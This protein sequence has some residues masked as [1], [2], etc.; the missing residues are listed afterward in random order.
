MAILAE[1]V[2]L[3]A[4]GGLHASASPDAAA[5]QKQEA[6]DPVCGMTVD[7]AAARHVT[8]WQGQRFAFCAAS[9]KRAFDEDPEKYAEVATSG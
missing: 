5:V 6:L 2:A 9:C 1:L 7:L 4:A 8:D 3:R